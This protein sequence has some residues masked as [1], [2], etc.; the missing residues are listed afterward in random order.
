MAFVPHVQV[1]STGH[2]N[3]TV[4]EHNGGKLVMK[5]QGKGD[6]DVTVRQALFP[7]EAPGPA[8]RV[9]SHA[10]YLK[11]RTFQESGMNAFCYANNASPA[12]K[13]LSWRQI[14]I[15]EECE[16]LR[17]GLKCSPSPL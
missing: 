7:V 3:G 8:R 4:R 11:R 15:A 12:G 13:T 10:M 16:S 9:L 5:C 1:F 2:A 6:P 17:G 14:S